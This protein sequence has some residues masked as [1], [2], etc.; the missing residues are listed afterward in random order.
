[1]YLLVWMGTW[2][3]LEDLVTRVLFVGAVVGKEGSFGLAV[4]EVE[5]SEVA[6]GK[7]LLQG[8]VHCRIDRVGHI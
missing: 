6:I 3:W 8:G 1:M 7:C 4:T 2:A 5:G